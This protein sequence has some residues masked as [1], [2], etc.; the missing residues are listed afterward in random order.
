MTT[1][2]ASSNSGQ[3]KPLMTTHKTLSSKPI[4]T[5][6]SCSTLHALAQQVVDYLPGKSLQSLKNETNMGTVGFKSSVPF[7]HTVL[8]ENVFPILKERE[9]KWSVSLKSKRDESNNLESKFSDTE[10]HF[11]CYDL[12]EDSVLSLLHERQIG[13]RKESAADSFSSTMGGNFLMYTH[14]KGLVNPFD[15]IDDNDDNEQMPLSNRETMHSGGSGWLRRSSSPSSYFLFGED[16]NPAVSTLNYIQYAKDSILSFIFGKSDASGGSAENLTES[17][18][19]TTYLQLLDMYG[20]ASH[21]EEM[22]DD[23]LDDWLNY[24]DQIRD[25][26]TTG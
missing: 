6:C 14:S 10:E 13:A 9:K 26:S 7:R 15:Q 5:S 8:T 18:P 4:L 17:R 3:L 25:Q 2:T 20:N 24:V 16:D 11:H 1:P 23:K 12:V 21:E 22:E 19:S